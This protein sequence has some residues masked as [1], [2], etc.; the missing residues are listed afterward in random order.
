[1]AE[2]T[3]ENIIVGKCKMC[4]GDVI[5]KEKIF[6]CSKADNKQVKK[7]GTDED[8]WVNEGCQF[9]IF[10]SSLKKLG[11][12]ELT[13]EEVTSLL[14]G[15]TVEFDLVSKGG[16]N[17]KKNGTLDQPNQDGIS[18]VKIDFKNK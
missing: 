10:R 1:M 8:I 6:V 17:Y 16:S 4:D 7:E 13:N 12:N 18:W 2:E 11:K 5:A 14:N 15:D 9:K 3:N